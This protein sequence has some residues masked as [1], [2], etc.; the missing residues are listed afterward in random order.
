M[1]NVLPKKI[2]RIT[3]LTFTLPNDFNGDIVDA[4]EAIVQYYSNI[5][6]VKELNDDKSTVE[7]LLENSS[8]VN[9]KLC[10]KYGIF[11]CDENG[12]YILQ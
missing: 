12:N 5:R 7:S 10:M 11:D 4:L 8:Y 9:N 6:N 3:D 2:V 1:A